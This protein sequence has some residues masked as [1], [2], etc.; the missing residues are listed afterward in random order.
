MSRLKL[1]KVYR[2]DPVGYDEYDAF[3]VAAYTAKEA[4]GYHPSA[5]GNRFSR[6]W[7]DNPDF[8]MSLM[9]GSAAAGTK[10]GTVILTSFRAG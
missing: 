9:I 1:W 6:T 7:P 4:E 8:I 10:P 5:S 3:V 2:I